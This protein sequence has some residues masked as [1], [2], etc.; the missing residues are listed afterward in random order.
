MTRTLATLALV[1]LCAAF[2]ASAFQAID[3]ANALYQDQPQA[4]ERDRMT[5]EPTRTTKPDDPLHGIA[6]PMASDGDTIVPYVERDDEMEVYTDDIA[7]AR[8][9][10]KHTG[11]PL[12]FITDHGTPV[13][14]ELNRLRPFVLPMS[15]LAALS[16][17]SPYIAVP[18]G[19]LER[20]AALADAENERA[21]A[22]LGLDPGSIMP[23]DLSNRRVTADEAEAIDAAN[24]AHTLAR[25]LYAAARGERVDWSKP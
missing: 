1:A 3:S 20:C 13:G 19:I 15:V 24:A 7:A 25:Q 6:W 9:V 18:I 23:S 8:A 10:A 16:I 14:E 22:S 5:D 2:V 11:T 17:D 4:Q 21:C 12:M